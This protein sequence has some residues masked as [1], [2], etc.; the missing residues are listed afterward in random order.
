MAT[1]YERP[2]RGWTPIPN[3][4]IQ[5]TELSP[6]ARL[7]LMHALSNRADWEE[8]AWKIAERLGFS[9]ERVI[10]ALAEL[11]KTGH[12]RKTATVTVPG[13]PPRQG[14]DFA[15]PAF[16]ESTSQSR[17]LPS[18]GNPTLAE[19]SQ[20]EPKVGFHHDGKIHR[21][22]TPSSDF[23][24]SENPTP[25]LDG[26]SNQTV[27]QLDKDHYHETEKTLSAEAPATLDPALEEPII[28]TGLNFNDP[29]LAAFIKSDQPPAKKTRRAPSRPTEDPDFDKAWE[30]YNFKES[31]LTAQKAWAKA[32]KMVDAQV[33]LNAIPAYVA[34]TLS[35]GEPERHGGGFIPRR[36][37]MAT[38]LN[39]ERWNDEIEVPKPGYQGRAGSDVKSQEG[40]EE[41]VRRRPVCKL[42]R[43]GPM[44]GD[45][46]W[47][48]AWYFHWNI[49]QQR[50]WTREQLLE[51]GNSPE[52]V[53]WLMQAYAHGIDSN[54]YQRLLADI[55]GTDAR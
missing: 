36:A 29:Q 51:T 4:L 47:N 16:V 2:E 28:M 43:S 41:R 7:V 37:L 11:K 40:A 46:G 1:Y 27:D 3:E 39:Q 23:P 8:P 14:W 34:T 19:S 55:E 52:D 26:S 35:K 31:K 32:R 18:S 22:E 10:K 12:A 54:L 6:V 33:I 38:W 45:L 15:W 17:V 25:L 20:G 53:D 42:M 21:R 49:E 50:H 13:R 48:R 44:P 9:R 24:S 30:L 5:T